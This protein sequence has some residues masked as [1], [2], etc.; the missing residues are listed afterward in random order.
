MKGLNSGEGCP[1]EICE[2]EGGVCAPLGFKAAGI[3]AGFRKTKKDLAA[4]LSDCLCDTAAVYTTNKVKGAPLIVTERHL[5]DGKA[6]AVICNS[7]NANTCAANG[8]A[9][10]EETCKLLADELGINPGDVVVCSTGIIGEPIE[11]ELFRAGIPKLAGALRSGKP[12]SGCSGS[13]HAAEAIMTTDRTVKEVAVSFK[14]GD[15]ACH[16]GGISKGSGMVNPKMA[17]VLS[18]LTTDISIDGALLRSI[19]RS[20]VDASFNMIS[21]DGNMSTNDTAVIMANGM[22]GNAKITGPGR[23]A[24]SFAAALR[25]LT[26]KLSREIAKDGEGAEKLIE[27]HVTGA[28]DVHIARKVGK[29]VIMSDLVKTAVHAGDANW[30]R[31]LCAVGYAGGEFPVDKVDIR[32]VSEAGSAL[33]CKGS[34]KSPFDGELAGAILGCDEIRIEVGLNSGTAS[35]M[36]YGCDLTY[37]YV[38][39]SGMYRT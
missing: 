1:V 30:G 32:L 28:P 10:A 39:I 36:A 38:K 16:I 18:F 21:V 35:A 17:T 20:D 3:H 8:V 34:T 23:D 5:K 14:L 24:D 11:M 4:I 37:G 27:C 12:D 13:R 6:M 22:A 25:V 19:F 15:K 31:I 26:S 9:A 33:V 29:S 2:A 7:G